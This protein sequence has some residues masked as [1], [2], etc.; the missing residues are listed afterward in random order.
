MKIQEAA[1]VIGA[2]WRALPEAD[3][4]QRKEAADAARAA[5][6]ASQGQ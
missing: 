5:W 6:K 3:K 4:Q 2:E 1:K